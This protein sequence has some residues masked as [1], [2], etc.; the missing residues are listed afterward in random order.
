MAGI[1]SRQIPRPTKAEGKCGEC[2]SF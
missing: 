2:Y 1:M